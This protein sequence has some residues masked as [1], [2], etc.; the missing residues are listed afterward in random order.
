MANTLTSWKEI[1]QYLGKGV[2]TVQRWEEHD[3][4]PVRRPSGH[5]SGVVLAFADERDRW[6]RS[7]QDADTPQARPSNSCDDDR[8]SS[9][10]SSAL[11]ECARLR[12]RL[13]EA[14]DLFQNLRL[15]R[16]NNTHAVAEALCRFHVSLLTL[17]CAEA[18]FEL[19]GGKVEEAGKLLV[20]VRAHSRQLAEGLKRLKRLPQLVA[21]PGYQ[22]RIEE[23]LLRL[24]KMML[25]SDAPATP[26]PAY[27]AWTEQ[28]FMQLYRASDLLIHDT[29]IKI[30]QK[31]QLLNETRKR[32]KAARPTR[33]SVVVMY[34]HS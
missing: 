21:N 5:D 12:L 8:F 23:I 31:E 13:A 18:E 2:R 29:K 10:Y 11:E 24:E 28:W 9:R 17:L 4:L 34:E 6:L 19:N 15:L 1:A 22:E 26:H 3:G 33:Q 14:K 27:S 20:Q 7:R 30:K 16:S 32:L 25:D